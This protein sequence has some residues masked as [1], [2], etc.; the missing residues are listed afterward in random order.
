M[1]P[2]KKYA[3]Q[4]VAAGFVSTV[5]FVA[6]PAFANGKT[7]SQGSTSR[8]SYNWFNNAQPASSG[9][10]FSVIERKRLAARVSQRGN[11]S[12]ICSPAGFGKK[13]R[14]YARN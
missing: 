9:N 12:Y 6:A 14:C 3:K 13:S 2:I 10:Q 8:I 7:V 4:A 5:V 1:K 11:G